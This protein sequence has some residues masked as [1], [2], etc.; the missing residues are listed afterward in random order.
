MAGVVLVPWYATML[1]GDKFAVALE[2]IAPVALR[3]GATSY[4]VYRSRD[5]GYKFFHYSEFAAKTDWERFWYGEEFAG[6]RADY[7]S[8]YQVPILYNWMTVVASGGIGQPHTEEA[9]GG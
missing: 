1:R 7:S 3:Y 2:E 8:W 9:V 6:W 5:D 4:H